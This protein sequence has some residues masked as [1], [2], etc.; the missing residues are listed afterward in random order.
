MTII[1][2]S[3][4]NARQP[5]IGSG[6][7]KCMWSA[8]ETITQSL[9]DELMSAMGGKRTL[10]S[11]QNVDAAQRHQQ[12]DGPKDRNACDEHPEPDRLILAS[13]RKRTHW[14]EPLNLSSSESGKQ[15]PGA[16]DGQSTGRQRHENVLVHRLRLPTL[17]MSAMA[18][19]R[20]RASP[21]GPGLRLEEN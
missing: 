7:W 1:P 10:V 4:T 16:K 11:H 14:V 20:P 2:T 18:R 9:T 21:A 13:T 15:D 6:R 17:P 3:P 8:P 12:A 19:R 5:C